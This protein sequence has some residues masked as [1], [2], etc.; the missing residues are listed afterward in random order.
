MLEKIGKYEVIGTL[1]RGS[2]GL[3]YKARDPEIDRIVAIKTLRKIKTKNTISS[4]KAMER[5]LV[6]ARSAGRLRHPNLITIFDLDFENEPPYIVM[7]Y[8]DGQT[9]EA[10]IRSQKSLPADLCIDYL[11]Q[12][13]DGLDIAHKEG[14]IHRDLKPA[15]IVVDHNSRVYILDFGVARM[16]QQ[17]NQN[18][19]GAKKEPVMGTPGYMSP[20]QI[21]NEDLDN[22]SDLFSLAIV[23]YECFSGSRPFQGRHYRE[24]LE[25]ILHQEPIPLTSLKDLPFALEKK[26]N[27]ALN[28]NKEER[29]SSAFEMVEAFAK[30]LKIKRAKVA[31]TAIARERLEA[32][33]ESSRLRESGTEW[34]VLQPAKE[35]S[36][37]VVNKNTLIGDLVSGKKDLATLTK[38]RL[39]TSKASGSKRNL[40]PVLVFIV[41]LLFL[42]G[43]SSVALVSKH[44]LENETEP[45]VKQVNVAQE[46][47]SPE[48]P[49]KGDFFDKSDPD[50]RAILTKS[51]S[52]LGDLV[53]A[54]R[55]AEERKFHDL[56][57]I[58]AE[59]VAHDSY[60]VRSE[61]IKLLERTKD[62]R[63]IPLLVQSLDDYDPT[64][65]AYAAQALG[66]I[67]AQKSLS[68]LEARLEKEDSQYVKDSIIKS[69]ELI[70]GYS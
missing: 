37:E 59:L 2:M 21:R 51:D 34:K 45:E 3:V 11:Y 26:I 52:D 16:S 67:K 12:L 8:V 27:Q 39:E 57:E 68:Y 32:I 46:L 4:E 50:I 44:V 5:M 28:K 60:V 20:E 64:V 62:T 47:P 33:K 10:I 36:T 31:S 13:A 43:V 66:S 65:R 9:L 19:L 15:N 25:K 6:E 22:R 30:A 14:V 1:G 29:F 63:G 23:A 35:A 38:E 53:K 49:V 58:S 55:Q 69:L 70:K 56:I 42:A 61:T 7:D 40:N 54:L 41:S 48:G 17:A 24:V 18:I